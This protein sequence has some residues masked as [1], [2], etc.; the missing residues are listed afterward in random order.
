M[1]LCPLLVRTGE[2]G[3]EM[4]RASPPQVHWEPQPKPMDMPP[5]L[6]QKWSEMAPTIFPG[7]SY[8]YSNI[9][10]FPGSKEFASGVEQPYLRSTPEVGILQ[11]FQW[12]ELL[13]FLFIFRHLF[14]CWQC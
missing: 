2:V 14:F 9:Q 10:N 1:S 12:Q 13:C 3:A 6:N 5:V 8:K 4:G 7:G 11:G